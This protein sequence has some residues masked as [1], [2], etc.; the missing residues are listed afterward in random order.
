M[1]QLVLNFSLKEDKYLHE[2]SLI[3]NDRLKFFQIISSSMIQEIKAYLNG[4]VYIIEQRDNIKLRSIDLRIHNNT[5]L[6][7]FKGP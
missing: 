6:L 4:I 1:E 2:I 3:L 5:I 7:Y